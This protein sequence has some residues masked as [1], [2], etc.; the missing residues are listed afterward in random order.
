MQLR[1]WF[2]GLAVRGR[3]LARV[4]WVWVAACVVVAL[5]KPFCLD[6]SCMTQSL[7]LWCPCFLCTIVMPKAPVKANPVSDVCAEPIAVKVHGYGVVSVYMIGDK[8]VNG[9]L[10]MH[11]ICIPLPVRT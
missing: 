1:A 10:R 5:H 8:F 7:G 2:G 11:S 3:A 4:Q 6:V 9:G